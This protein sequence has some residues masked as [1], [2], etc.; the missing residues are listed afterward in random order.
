MGFEDVLGDN[1][2]GHGPEGLE[3]LAVRVSE[4]GYIVEQGIE[5]D[6]GDI[7][8]IKREG[9]APGDSGFRS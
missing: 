9:D 4:T 5:P 8:L 1:V 2:L 7:I 3:Q 6:I